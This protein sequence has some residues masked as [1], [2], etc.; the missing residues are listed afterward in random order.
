M[1]RRACHSRL[2]A[3]LCLR[4][5]GAALAALALPA[6]AVLAAEGGGG[7][8]WLEL[9]WKLVNFLVLAG[10]IYHFGRR[11][12]ADLFRGAAERA[13]GLLDS[14]RQEARQTED[15]LAEQKRKIDGLQAEL[16]R[17]LAEAREDARQEQERL[18]GEA[19]ETAERIR[20]QTHHLVQQEF[21][22]ARADL[23]RELAG[24]TVRLAEGMIRQRLD[25]AGQERLVDATI[26]QL[27]SRS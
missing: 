18:T 16:E 3:G 8:P 19:R 4:G 17:W 13:K 10:I 7:D 1:S 20:V 27:G 6:P 21:R 14:A 25:D 11:P 12:I 2:R 15:A 23:Q 5:A 9:L 24:E 26:D 22:K